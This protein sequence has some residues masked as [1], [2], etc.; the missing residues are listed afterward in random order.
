MGRDLGLDGEHGGMTSLT[1]SQV[2]PQGRPTGGKINVT[3][4]PSN[5]IDQGLGV[6]VRVNDHYANDDA[7][8]GAGERLMG[9]FAD[10]FDTS[11]KR[12][13]SIVDHIMSLAVS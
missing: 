5:R 11:L 3:V 2:S 7:S 8:P 9:L 1:M 4:E 10:N 13:D 12:S 6:Y